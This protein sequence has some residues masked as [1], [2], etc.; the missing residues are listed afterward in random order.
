MNKWLILLCC[1]IFI[2][3]SLLTTGLTRALIDLA[4]FSALLWIV[5]R[6][7]NSAED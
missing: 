1:M 4:A 7:Q 6:H 5:L 2:S 3:A